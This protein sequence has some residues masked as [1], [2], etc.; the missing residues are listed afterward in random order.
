[1]KKVSLCK[2]PKYQ[3]LIK[4][5]VT[6]GKKHFI[7]LSNF[8]ECSNDIRN[9]YENIDVYKQRKGKKNIALNDDCWKKTSKSCFSA[10][11]ILIFLIALIT[12][13]YINTPNNIRLN[14]TTLPYFPKKK[15]VTT[16]YLK[17]FCRQWLEGFKKDQC[18]S[19][20]ETYSFVVVD[21]NLLII[22]TSR[23]RRF[24]KILKNFFENAQYNLSWTATT[25]SS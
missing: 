19:T 22:F 9:V 6:V 21:T 10:T 11:K 23:K 16:N 17:S 25:F 20:K 8:T 1:M 3:H 12:Q 13:P 7:H 14:I 2:G 4:H 15:S 18:H 5:R 24:G